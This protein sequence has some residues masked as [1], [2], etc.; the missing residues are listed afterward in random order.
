MSIVL[1]GILAAWTCNA[2]AATAT[3]QF[4]YDYSVDPPCAGNVN[5]KNCIDHFQIFDITA[6]P[7]DV[8]L[9]TIVPSTNPPLPTGITPVPFNFKV[10]APYGTRKWAVV[11]VARDAS[12]A[13]VSSDVTAPAAQATIMVRPGAPAA[14]VV[15]LQ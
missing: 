10:G 1:L 9:T 6:H 14:F 3:G 13:M 15:N 4:T 12:G 7:S 8:V 5:D 2:I 11:A